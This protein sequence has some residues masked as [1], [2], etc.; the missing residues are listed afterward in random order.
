MN[1]LPNLF[2]LV[3]L[4]TPIFFSSSSA[5]I[6]ALLQ[7]TKQETLLH[8][9]IRIN[10]SCSGVNML[11]C[12]VSFLFWVKNKY[13]FCF[14]PFTRV[15][16]L[17]DRAKIWLKRCLSLLVVS[18]NHFLISTQRPLI[19]FSNSVAIENDWN[20]KAGKRFF[21]I[22]IYSLIQLA[23]S[24]EFH[25]IS[26]YKFDK[27]NFIGLFL[28]GYGV[29]SSCYKLPRRRIRRESDNLRRWSREWPAPLHHQIW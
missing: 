16:L 12:C 23:S 8:S 17:Q 15:V 7:I 5:I 29:W 9:W 10:K 11:N 18:W 4:I 6:S 14:S 21:L 28:A 1:S 27:F 3:K 13:C 20:S 26:F 25:F 22:F 24:A 2:S 19:N